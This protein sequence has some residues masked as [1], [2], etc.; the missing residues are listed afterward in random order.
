[1]KSMKKQQTFILY[2]IL[3]SC[4]MSMF[5]MGLDGHALTSAGNNS[6]SSITNQSFTTSDNITAI[7]V[8]E[9]NLS[10]AIIKGI[11]NSSRQKTIG[12]N[13]IFLIFALTILSGVFRLTQEIYIF[14]SR[15][16]VWHRYYL[17]AYIHAK[18]GRKGLSSY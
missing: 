11:K 4:I 17:I 1:M 3:I 2:F 14:F 13:I 5:S 7:H 9:G 16:Y 18:D 8:S 12:R 15:L 10:L 6:S